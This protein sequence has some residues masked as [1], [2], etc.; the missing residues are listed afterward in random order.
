MFSL[1]GSLE[2][3]LSAK[4]VDMLDPVKRR[5]TEPRPRPARGR[6]RQPL[7]G[8]VG[9]LPMISEIVRS[10]ANIDNG[11]QTRFVQLLPRPVPA[12]LRRLRA[13]A[14]PPDSAGRARGDARLHRL[15]PGLAER[16][17][18]D[19]PH[20]PRAARHLH[21]H[22]G[23]DAGD[24]FAGGRGGGHPPEAGGARPQRRAARGPVPARHR[25][26]AARRGRRAARAARGRLQQ[27]PRAQEA[28]P[29]SM[30]RRSTSSWTSSTRGWWTTR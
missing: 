28:H 8:L 20:R 26:A 13:V 23:R 22:A 24:G 15:A 9:G 21:V 14:D 3:L 29:R 16:V 19:V 12:A 5:K 27:L 10:K 11:A 18:E 6:R 7:A 2:S 4:A 17:R 30:P 25:G 1:V